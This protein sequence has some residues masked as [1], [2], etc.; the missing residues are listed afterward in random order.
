MRVAVTG[1]TGMIGRTAVRALLARGD[2]VVALSRDAD[3]ARERLGPRVEA[4]SWAD[5]G[6]SR[7]PVRALSGCDAVLNLMGEPIEQRWTKAAKQRIRDSRVSGTGNLVE[8][9]GRADPRP[10]VLVSQS[11]SGRY[12]ARGDEPVGENARPGDDF[13]ASVVDDWE[14]EARRA[15]ELGMRVAVARTGVVLSPSGG[16]LAKMLPPFKL[17][18]GGPVAGGAQYLP[19]I[20]LDDE[21]EALV[22]LLGSDAARG[23]VNVCAPDAP[24]NREFSKA[25]GRALRRPAL[26]PVPGFAVKLLYGEM[27]WVVTTGVRMLPRRLL[28]LGYEFR[29]PDLEEALRDVL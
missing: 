17:G 28:E 16:A 25:L 6:A 20:H 13:L 24:T 29:R 1:A 7:P 19:W 23:P 18:V 9:L 8:G 4:F 10:K 5:P 26:I 27:A 3:K 22:F 11:G 21:A 2:E 15:E 12:G 14:R